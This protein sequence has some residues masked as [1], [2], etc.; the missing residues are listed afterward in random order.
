M[1]Q[2]SWLRA[3]GIEAPGMRSQFCCGLQD[4]L[5]TPQIIT[6]ITIKVS[7]QPGHTTM[8]VGGQLYQHPGAWWH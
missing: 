2:V 5:A 1:W 8:E 3:Q 6:G 4:S 7:A